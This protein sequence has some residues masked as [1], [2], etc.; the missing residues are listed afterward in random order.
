M[1][2]AESIRRS[3]RRWNPLD[4]ADSCVVD[5]V[6]IG[7][8]TVGHGDSDDPGFHASAGGFAREGGR[9][10]MKPIADQIRRTPPFGSPKRR[11]ARPNEGKRGR[12]RVVQVDPPHGG[13][14]AR[15]PPRQGR[16]QGSVAALASRVHG[17]PGIA[18]LHPAADRASRA[19]LHGFPGALA[20]VLRHRIVGGRRRVS[21]T[22]ATGLSDAAKAGEPAYPR[23][24]CGAGEGRCPFD[25]QQT[26]APVDCANGG[27]ALVPP[28]TA[29][30]D[31]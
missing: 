31:G 4:I 17:R 14:D 6:G 5:T 15:V 27:I 20:G 3:R 18:S 13:T 1:P 24:N 9:A 25:P 8:L 19:P 21:D 22:S 28:V 23:Y 12:R 7:P 26:P 11:V 30:P 10:R 16:W 29:R 2:L